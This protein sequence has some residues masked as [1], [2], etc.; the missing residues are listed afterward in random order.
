M[1]SPIP[2]GM[3]ETANLNISGQDIIETCIFVKAGKQRST[4]RTF[5]AFKRIR[6]SFRLQVYWLSLLGRRRSSPIRPPRE[7]GKIAKRPS[8]ES[9]FVAR[10][11]PAN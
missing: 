7:K 9:A 11:P 2:G 5:I 10:K 6:N 4:R 3:I 1:A 8:L